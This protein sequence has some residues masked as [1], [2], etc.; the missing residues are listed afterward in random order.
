M[1]VMSCKFLMWKFTYVIVMVTETRTPLWIKRFRRF[2]GLLHDCKEHNLLIVEVALNV[3]M[4]QGVMSWEVKVNS[5][6]GIIYLD[7][8]IL[9][10]T[11]NCT[12]MWL[13]EAATLACLTISI[14]IHF[15]FHLWC[16]QKTKRNSENCT[17]FQPPSCN[18][19]KADC[20]GNFC[21]FYWIVEKYEHN[22]SSHTCEHCHQK[23]WE[24]RPPK[25]ERSH[26]HPKSR[27]LAQALHFSPGWPKWCIEGVF[28][29][30][31]LDEDAS[32]M[33][34]QPHCS[35]CKIF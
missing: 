11:T 17:S 20:P 21:N 8:C 5:S 34:L 28:L 6:E 12:I 10:Y 4:M 19:A 30:P 35:Y 24:I 16:I 27:P 31:D 15:L 22:W 29:Y 25:R 33:L 1:L 14:Y 32:K 7:V 9:H 18:I 23:V 2:Y 13:S 26:R 3:L